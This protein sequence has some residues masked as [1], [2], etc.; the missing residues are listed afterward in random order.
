MKKKTM[1]KKKRD[2]AKNHQTGD[3]KFCGKQNMRND[4]LKRHILKKHKNELMFKDKA[5]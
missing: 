1:K 3:C 5:I 4:N 2:L